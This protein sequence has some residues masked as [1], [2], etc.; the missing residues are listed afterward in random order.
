[1]TERREDGRR[2]L[3]G[4][5]AEKP[6]LRTI[7]EITG[8]AVTTVSRALGGAPQIALETRRRVQEVADEIGYLPDRAA[9]RLRTGRTNVISLI[10]DPHEEILNFATSIIKGLSDALRDTSY[11]LVITPHFRNEPSLDPVRYILRN[12]TAD[13]MIFSRTEPFDE[14]VRLLLEN[15]FPFVCHGRTELATPHPYVD[16]DNEVFAYEA[17]MR[18]IREGRRK[19]AIIL[20][21]ARFTFCQHMRYGFLKAVREHGLPFETFDAISLDSTSDEIQAAVTRRLHEAAP[22]D[23]FV[24]GGEISALA[25]MAALTDHGLQP[26]RDA[27]VVSK[28]T[29]EFFAPVRPRIP[30]I[31]EDLAAAGAALGSTLLKRIAGAPVDTLQVL[32]RPREPDRVA[33]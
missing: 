1:M 4:D 8:L 27:G 19:P 33:Q 7:A 3:P 28:K 23:G 14:R 26:G 10:L 16:Y 29:S 2:E 30:T 12:R 11:H 20:P 32:H 17:T 15:D 5:L 25:V 18:L 9:Q 31:E 22:P 21:P 24:L 6:T 13:G